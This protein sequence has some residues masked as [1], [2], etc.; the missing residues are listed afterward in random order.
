MA[1]VAAALAAGA[2]HAAS[3]APTIKLMHARPLLVVGQHF[4]PGEHVTV[5]ARGMR[6]TSRKVIASHGSFSVA[7]EG[8]AAARCLG[9]RVVA[10]GSLGSRAAL[11]L[12]RPLCFPRPTVVLPRVHLPGLHS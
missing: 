6:T 7:L 10:I 3:P 4:Q 12:P 11:A 9:L 8:V 2:A 5:I 1:I